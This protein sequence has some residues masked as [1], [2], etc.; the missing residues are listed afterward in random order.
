MAKMSEYKEQMELIKK[1]P[2][3]YIRNFY[4]E[5][6]PHMGRKVMSILSLLPASHIAPPLTDAH[7]KL[8]RA[9]IN[10]LLLAVPGT[11]KSALSAHF[12]NFAYE[13]FPFESITES[14]LNIV[15]NYRQ[16]VTLIC[17]D[18]ARIFSN[19]D[20]V[21]EMENIIGDEGKISRLTRNTEDTETPIHTIAYFAGTP[22]NLSRTI[23]DGMIFRVSPIIIYHTPE[24]HSEILENVNQNIGRGTNVGFLNREQVI[25]DYFKLIKTVQDKD[26]NTPLEQ[27]TGYEIPEDFR[28]KITDEIIP[29][30]AQPFKETN[31]EFVR[32]LQQSY[33]YMVSHAILNMFN[34]KIKDGKILIEQR[35]YDVA[36]A[37]SQKEIKTKLIILNSLNKMSEKKF[38]NANEVKLW[39]YNQKKNNDPV[40]LEEY[41]TIQML[42]KDQ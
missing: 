27:I 19:K 34:R 22:D 33:R 39:A 24:E 26:K 13:P 16:R 12:K 18:I 31:F 1:N 41:K 6:Y 11:A 4:E 25:I 9:R 28:K 8:I 2:Y 5:L 42:V 14:K 23:Q 40:S 3:D 30:F 20:L 32:E 7:G 38:R 29:L 35:D 37:L 15:L 21:K 10:F 17:S 36:L